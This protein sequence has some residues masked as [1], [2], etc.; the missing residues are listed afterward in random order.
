MR[1]M[2]RP[3]RFLY[4]LYRLNDDGTKTLVHECATESTTFRCGGLAPG[5][6]VTHVHQLSPSG[7]RS[8]PSRIPVFVR[9]ARGSM[10]VSRDTGLQRRTEAASRVQ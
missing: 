8:E 2:A 1:I 6:Y 7:A 4:E 3:V 10:R 5:W 9:D